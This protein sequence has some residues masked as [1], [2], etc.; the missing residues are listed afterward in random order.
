MF[1]LFRKKPPEKSKT[2]TWDFNLESI[3]KDVAALIEK[4]RDKNAP[5][6]IDTMSLVEQ[7]VLPKEGF[8]LVLLSKKNDKIA[9]HQFGSN[10]TSDDLLKAFMSIWK[11]IHVDQDDPSIGRG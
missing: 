5:Q 9:L 1:P 11:S 4:Y 6:G 7:D 2:Q 10:I 3:E 8:Y